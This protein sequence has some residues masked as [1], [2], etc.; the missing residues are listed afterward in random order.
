[1]SKAPRATLFVA[2][3]ASAPLAAATDGVTVIYPAA[4]GISPPLRGRATGKDSSSP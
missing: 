1:M 2:L 4:V 3:L